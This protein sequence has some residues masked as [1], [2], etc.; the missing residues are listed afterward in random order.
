[1]RCD[2]ARLHCTN[3]AAGGCVYGPKVRAARMLLQAAEAQM[4]VLVSSSREGA[5]AHEAQ[6]AELNK[7]S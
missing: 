1:M 5:L 2:A 6:L 4:G 7:V 3:L